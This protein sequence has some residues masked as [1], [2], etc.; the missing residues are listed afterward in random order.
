MS[1]ASPCPEKKACLVFYQAGFGGSPHSYSRLFL[2]CFL[3]CRLC[4][5]RLLGRLLTGGFLGCFCFRA[6]F[7]LLRGWLGFLCGFS[8][9]RRFRFLGG[10]GLFGH[11]FRS[12]HLCSLRLGFGLWL[13]L[14]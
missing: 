13:G 7:G 8:L 9:L 6:Y 1:P 10:L 14:A 5:C 3:L 11:A 4:L 12:T 2:L